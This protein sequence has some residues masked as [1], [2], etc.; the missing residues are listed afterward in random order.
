MT[1]QIVNALLLMGL[2]GAQRVIAEEA[3]DD[4]PRIEMP[5]QVYKTLRDALESFP[6]PESRK[7]SAIKVNG[8]ALD[9]LRKVRWPD[10]SKLERVHLFDLKNPERF[11]NAWLVP[12]GGDELVVLMPDFTTRRMPRSA[13]SRIEAIKYAEELDELVRIVRGR[14][15]GTGKG[16]ESSIFSDYNGGGPP[17]QAGIYHACAAAFLGKESEAKALV[18]EALKPWDPFPRVYDHWAWQ[19]F[20]RGIQL[21]EQ[22]APRADVLAQWEHVLVRK[23]PVVGRQVHRPPQQH[24]LMDQPGPQRAGC[25]CRAAAGTAPENRIHT[26]APRPDWEISTAAGTPRLRAAFAYASASSIAPAPSKSATRKWQSLALVNGYRPTNAWPDKCADSTS[27]VR[28][29]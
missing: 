17:Y 13:F 4:I 24:R 23:Q 28:G 22:G 12:G 21:L 7:A 1:R 11:F 26:W 15:S 16:W 19:A 5:E 3:D 2:L 8:D 9:H 20:Y 25:C 6:Y 27:S 29:K 10:L 14:N 18:H